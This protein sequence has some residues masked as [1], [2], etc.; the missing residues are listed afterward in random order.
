MTRH[1]M[2]R[3]SAIGS[4]FLPAALLVAGCGI[5]DLGLQADRGDRPQF[6]DWGFDVAAM[7]PAIAPGDDFYEYVNGT[8][9][10]DTAI[11]ADRIQVGSRAFVRERN[12]AIIEEMIIEFARPGA[13]VGLSPVERK[14]GDLYASFIDLEQRN[15]R[16]NCAP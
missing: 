13:R 6:G 11:P 10:D 16:G 12:D 3:G 2:S 15:E 9:I 14:V 4:L 8:W 1:C 5:E 7:N